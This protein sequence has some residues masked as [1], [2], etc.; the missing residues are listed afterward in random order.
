MQLQRTQI[1]ISLIQKRIATE[2]HWTEM[3]WS[4]VDRFSFSSFHNVTV[5]ENSVNGY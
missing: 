2:M 3:N 4:S 1:H 5:I